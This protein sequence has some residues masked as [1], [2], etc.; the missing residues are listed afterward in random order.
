MSKVSHLVRKDSQRACF[1]HGLCVHIS[2]QL[3]R[4]VATITRL[5]AEKQGGCID[6]L[7]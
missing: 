2:N 3:N 5:V 4:A 1:V 7:E 6:K